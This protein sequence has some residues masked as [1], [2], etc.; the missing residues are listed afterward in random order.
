M[1]YPSLH[2][3][4]SEKMQRAGFASNSELHRKVSAHIGPE[5][6]RLIING[7]KLPE[8]DKIKAIAK[9]LNID[10]VDFLCVVENARL[11][12]RGLSDVVKIVPANK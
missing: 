8:T 9:V 7:E 2:K 3:Y 1:R 4:V 6:L 12:D 5:F 11:K 10:F